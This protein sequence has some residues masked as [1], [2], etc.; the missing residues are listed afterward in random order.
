MDGFGHHDLNMG[1][2]GMEALL[3]CGGWIVRYLHRKCGVIGF[4]SFDM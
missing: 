4:S 1:R 3:W 2:Q